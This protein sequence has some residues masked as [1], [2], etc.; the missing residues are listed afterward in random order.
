MSRTNE[1]NMYAAACEMPHV[2]FARTTKN[3]KRTNASAGKIVRMGLKN[4]PVIPVRS[5]VHASN[6]CL[7][8]PLAGRPNDFLYWPGNFLYRRMSPRTH[9][10]SMMTDFQGVARVEWN[11]FI[12]WQKGIGPN[13]IALNARSVSS[14]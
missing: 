1:R 5:N 8:A 13:G 12:S 10:I 6:P 4:N 7:I 9:S 14:R 11:T 3:E 2:R